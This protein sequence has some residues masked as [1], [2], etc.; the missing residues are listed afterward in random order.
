[1]EDSIWST[2]LAQFRDRTG[3]TDPVPAG[4]SISAVAACLALALIAK[5]LKIVRGRKNFS[6]DAPR[7]EALIDAVQRESAI[8]TGLADED[9]RAFN[10][11]MDSIRAKQPVDKTMREEAIGEA[12]GI[13]M[14]AARATV[15]GLALCREAASL[16]PTGMTAAD[17]G[18]ARSLLT[19]AAQAMLLS[20]RS[21][22]R[23]LKPDDPSGIEISA[24]CDR[25]DRIISYPVPKH[26][27]RP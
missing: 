6:G 20:V 10:R 9:I 3:G 16:C 18:S 19:G 21:N 1:M 15:R 2:S 27:L 12:I 8:L 14:D 26:S 13:P 7:F 23:Q 25:L 22:L 4:V 11:Y 24:E 17:L 5:V